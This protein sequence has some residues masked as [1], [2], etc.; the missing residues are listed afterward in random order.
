MSQ[1][2]GI[3]G[4]LVVVG[5]LLLLPDVLAAQSVTSATIAGTA[6]DATGAVLPGVTVEASSPA[7]IEKTRSAVTDTQ[8]NYKILDLRPGQYTVTFTLP[9]FATLKRDGLELATGLTANVTVEMRV[10]AVEESVTVTGA[11]PVVDVQNVRYQQV[12]SREVWDALP[13]G[14]TLSSYVSLTLGA[15]MGAS[16]QD[17]GGTKGDKAGGGAT[18]SYHGAGQNDQAIVV[19]GLAVN[20]QTTGGGPWTRTTVN[21]D[22]A[23]EETTIGSGVSAEQENAG[24]L[25]NLIPRDGGNLLSGTFALNGS[26]GR[27]QSDNLTPELVARGV[28]VQ[29][30]VVKLYD[31]GGGA[32]GPL[33]KDK[34]WFYASDRWWNAATVVPGSFFNATPEPA[35][36]AIP[37]YTPD[38]SRPAVNSAPNHND[39]L[40]LTFQPTNAHKLTFFG[41]LQS[42]C[43]CYYSASQSRAPEAGQNLT[44]PY[45][46]KNVYQGNWNYVKGSRWLFSIGNS[47][48]FSSSKPGGDRIAESSPTAIPLMDLNTG[49]AWN[50]KGD[51]PY[52]TGTCCSP[53]A[54]GRVVGR[55]WYHDQKY[56]A[57]YSTGSH[58]FKVGAR[59]YE[60]GSRP[61]TSSYNDTA[62]GPVLVSVRGGTNGVAPVP[63]SILL[64][65]NPQGPASATENAGGSDVLMTA[66]YAQEQWT[67]KKLTLNLGVRYDGM[68]GKYNAYTTVANNYRGSFSFPEV[69]NS[70]NWNDIAPRIGAAFD[71]FGNGKTAIK[72]S[73]GRFVVHQTGAGSSPSGSLGFGNGTRTWDD[74]NK[75]FFPDC[76]LL[77]PLKNGECGPLP[78]V[79]R[80]IPTA[81]STFYDPATLVGWG[82]RPYV[83]NSSVSVQQELR[84]GVG[85][86]VGYFRTT[87][88]NITVTQNR[89]VTPADFDQYCL[90]APVDSLLGSV[91][92]STLCGLYDP[93]ATAFGNVNNLVTLASNFGDAVNMYNGVDIGVNARFGHGGV[94]QG[95][96]STGQQVTDNCYLNARPDITFTTAAGV[97]STA[98]TPRNSQYCRSV[99][100]WTAGTQVKLLGNY[101]LPWW[102]VQMSATFQNLSGPSIGANR[103]YR[104]AEIA[105][106]L[107]RALS[108]GGNVSIQL[109]PLNSMYEPRFS[110]TDIRFT[111]T[112]RIQKLRAQGQF[113]VYNLFNSSAVLG[114]NSTYGTTWL[115]PSSILGARML[116]FGMQLDWK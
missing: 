48:F 40:R 93:T 39:N 86:S 65:I 36:G 108:S 56:T 82:V 4:G 81:P 9:G 7:L 66:L 17:V 91:S 76:N 22:R 34:L 115:R 110:E 24:I 95:G 30:K 21:N 97:N 103:S 58:T 5:L 23:F 79:N 84:P 47:S 106:T 100:S 71:L 2:R 14:K 3:F 43:N 104:S 54:D 25:I 92:G 113:D 73:W 44:A 27:F 12:L 99:P 60:Y 87:N 31:A 64:L 42:A 10:G 50:A 8:G 107:N 68:R 55:S 59:T 28:P 15:T 78:N 13:T 38:L 32:G 45:G 74:A 33:K 62:F 83:W 1:K 29:G 98:G 69:K 16:G 20:A 53:F 37:I 6:K 70:P 88:G 52:P 80:G 35:F 109:L 102:G 77:D 85:V 61:G 101:P 105:P 57:T 72:G 19:D 67:L 94:L 75:N 41:E 63:A 96:V 18:F 116:K 49:F 89:A 11:S 26:S 90:T 114:V 46:S 111:K 112:L 51:D